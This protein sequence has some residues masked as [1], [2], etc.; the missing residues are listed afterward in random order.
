MLINL[1][2]EEFKIAIKS[3]KKTADQTRQ[4]L[5]AHQK[6]H[7]YIHPAWAELKQEADAMQAL[8][9]KMRRFCVSTNPGQMGPGDDPNP[10]A[11][12]PKGAGW[13]DLAEG[14]IG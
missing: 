1:D 8:H 11:V 3:L 7:N 12:M 2:S 14:R 13:D 10:E 6:E 4:M 5:A 9:Y